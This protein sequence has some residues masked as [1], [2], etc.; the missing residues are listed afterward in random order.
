MDI[1]GVKK[2]LKKNDTYPSKKFGQNFLINQDI[3]QKI[4]NTASL[5]VNDTVLEIGAGIGNLTLELAKKADRVIAIEKD[6][7][8]C[9]ILK[10]VLEKENIKNVKIIDKDVL[11]YRTPDI[12]YKLI[13]NLPYYITSPVIR[14]FLEAKRKPKK[15]ILMVQ[16]E[17]AQRICS[18]PGKMNLLA[19]SVQFY[20]KPEIKFFVSKACFWPQPKVNSAIIEI[21]PHKTFDSDEFNKLFF[22]IVRAGFSHPRKQLINNLS[23]E[24]K[25]EKEKVRKWLLKSNL[26]P[27]L[28][29]EALAIKDW[30]K[31]TENYN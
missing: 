24:L 10:D 14:K 5:S 28:R 30:M 12:K 11:E 20:A 19:V 18:K 26:L 16:K 22:K 27:K 25:M 23:Q 6:R 7:K 15:M 2:L 1:K 31:L 4:I 13:A 9:V 17:V 8:M 21:I 3:L 29:A